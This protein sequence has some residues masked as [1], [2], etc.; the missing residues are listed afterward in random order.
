VLERVIAWPKRAV[1]DTWNRFYADVWFRIAAA[2]VVACAYTSHYLAARGVPIPVGVYVATLGGLAA[3]VTLRK[4]PSTPEK[5]LWIVAITI[6]MVAEIH[7][8]YVEADKQNKEAEA[9]STSLGLTNKGLGKTLEGLTSV[10]G[11][12][13]QAADTSKTQFD[14]TIDRVNGVLKTSQENL[15]AMMGKGSIPCIVPQSHGVTSQ[16]KIT[17]VLWNKGKHDLTGVEV[18]LLSEREWVNLESQEKTPTLLGTISPVW[19]KTIL[20]VV[21]E[22]NPKSG[23]AHY[24]AE[25]WTQ[26]GFYTESINFRRG[27]YSLP[28]AYQ[29]FLTKQEPTMVTPVG[30]NRTPAMTLQPIQIMDCQSKEWSDDLGDGK[31]IPRPPQ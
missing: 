11:K 12:L 13:D 29:Y 16:G 14:T 5:A 25:I 1:R 31:P 26:N 3:A 4:E 17:L 21:P 8:L 2:T 15:D 7:N 30:P 24:T 27:K 10:V 9:I 19:P 6:L 22:I 28:W 23:M 20:G 18:R